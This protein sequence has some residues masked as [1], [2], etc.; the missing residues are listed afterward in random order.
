MSKSDF[1]RRQFLT[2]AAFGVAALAA[3]APREGFAQEQPKKDAPAPDKTNAVGWAVA[4]LGNFALTQILPRM[5]NCTNT[6]VTG[7]ITRDPEGKGKKI[8]SEYGVDPAAVVNLENMQKLADRKDI[9]VVY[10]ITPN[11][12]HKEYVLAALKAGKHVFCEKPFATTVEDCQI[13]VDEAKKAGKLLGIG[14]RC[15]FEPFNIA[16]IKALRDGEIGDITMITGELGFQV[17][18]DTPHGSWRIDKKLAGGGPLP[19]IGVYAV[20]AA[21][22][23]TGEEPSHV[24]GSTYASDDPRFK[25]V[26][27]TCMFH[28]K[29]PSG[30]QAQFATSYN[31]SGANRWRVVGTK[32]WIELEPAIHYDHNKVKRSGNKELKTEPSD[33]FVRMMD[34]FSD[35][36]KTGRKPKATGEDGLLDVKYITAIYESAANES[37]IIKVS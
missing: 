30:V 33:Q 24:S 18:P 35:C 22:F 37:K 29:F 31:I 27:E 6:K 14:Y 16:V 10:V 20:N 36:V 13:M 5:R 21:R 34:D 4:G 7:L 26:E 23:L 3:V 1:S 12:L 11:G 8:A 9:D 2:S 32:G 25:E 17:N 15:H 19:D 28:F